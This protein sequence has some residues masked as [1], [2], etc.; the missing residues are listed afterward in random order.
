MLKVKK[1]KQ[2][3]KKERKVLKNAPMLYNVLV[4]LYKKEYNQ[5]FKSKD[6]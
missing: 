6:K 4:S 5:T 2:S 1:K 3:K